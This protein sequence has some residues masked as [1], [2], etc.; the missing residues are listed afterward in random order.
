MCCSS[1]IMQGLILPEETTEARGIR[2]SEVATTSVLQTNLT[3]SD[4]H[5]FRSMAHFLSGRIFDN[6]ADLEQRCHK[7]FASKRKDWYLKG[8]ENLSRQWQRTI[9]HNGIFFFS[10]LNFINKNEKTF[11]QH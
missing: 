10:N 8:I 7:F 6:T 2:W 3:P 9:D 11:P 1:K 4:F 5:L